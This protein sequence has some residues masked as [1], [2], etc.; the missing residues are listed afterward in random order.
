MFRLLCS[1]GV[2]CSVAAAP[3][4]LDSVAEAESDTAMVSSEGS[5][6][7]SARSERKLA[8]AAKNNKKK[9]NPGNG[10]GSNA[11]K[12]VCPNVVQ[13]SGILIK[14]A[15]PGHISQ[16][17]P[18]APGFAMV[19]GRSCVSSFPASVFFSDGTLAFK[20][21]YYGRWEGNGQPRAY[22]GAG[23]VAMCSVS[24]VVSNSRKSGRDKSAYLKLN[25]NTCA[26]FTPGARNDAGF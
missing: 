16:G 23:G 19:C 8:R 20:L 7:L 17:D 3:F 22:C 10:N 14:N 11:F 25:K 26:R 6:G 1:L 15:Y 24:S 12:K 18:R 13:L 21:G 9:N 4:I 5:R 2:A